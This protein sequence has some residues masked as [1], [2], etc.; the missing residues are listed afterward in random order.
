MKYHYLLRP[1]VGR[2]AGREEL[3]DYLR[4]KLPNLIFYAEVE[5]WFDVDQSTVPSLKDIDAILDFKNS[6]EITV[7][8]FYISPYKRLFYYFLSSLKI[9]DLQ[10]CE[11]CDRITTEN[12]VNFWKENKEKFLFNL[13]DLYRETDGV[14]IHHK[15]EYDTL[16]EDLRK[17]PGLE[18]T[19]EDLVADYQKILNRY[20]E[21]YTEEIREWVEKE[22]SEE[23][24]VRGYTF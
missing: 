10:D 2:L 19:P 14:I 4:K 11:T 12:F 17:I 20:K 21:F 3:N 5:K 8:A 24:L 9:T 22:F 13:A 18:S 7:L 15:L 1:C 6:K 16:A 23:I